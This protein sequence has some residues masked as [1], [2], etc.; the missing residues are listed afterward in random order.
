MTRAPLL[1][2]SWIGLAVLAATAAENP[3][4]TKPL[5]PGER[6]TTWAV[7][8]EKRGLPNLHQVA[9]GLYR[10]AQPSTAGMTQLKEMGVKTVVNLRAG[11]SDEKKL[12]DT[13]LEYERFYMKPWHSEDE[14][15]I[16]FL[17]IVT[18][19]NVIVIGSSPRIPH[20]NHHRTE[21]LREAR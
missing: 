13:G 20:A 4:S 16:R 14:D 21:C 7:P 9:P 6:P 18:S 8:V 15:V 1:H 11:H 10:G 5:P 12:R 17:Q 2:W 19:T 3:L